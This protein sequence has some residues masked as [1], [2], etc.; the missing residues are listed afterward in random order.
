MM[1]LRL[2]P[3]G[4]ALELCSSPLGSM[5][6]TLTGPTPLCKGKSLTWAAQM[7]YW[8]N[9][10]SYKAISP[11]CPAAAQALASKTGIAYNTQIDMVWLGVREEGLGT[12]VTG[13]GE[14]S[15]TISFNWFCPECRACRTLWDKRI[16]WRKRCLPKATAPLVTSIISRP[17]F[18]ST[19]TWHWWRKRHHKSLLSSLSSLQRGRVCLTC[20]RDSGRIVD[21][22]VDLKCR[23]MNHHWAGSGRITQVVW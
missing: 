5:G 20:T 2:Y 6:I 4:L 19:E 21:N 12:P 14:A 16:S 18:C 22:L 15:L 23:L 3:G 9:M 10:A 11:L 7:L 8:V 13:G 1:A 17:W